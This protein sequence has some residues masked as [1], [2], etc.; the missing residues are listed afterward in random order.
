F[1]NDTATTEIY[2]LSLHDALPIWRG[3]PRP[4]EVDGHPTG[5]ERVPWRAARCAHGDRGLARLGQGCRRRGVEREPGPLPRPRPLV[6]HAVG[7]TAGPADDR[8]RAVA[9]RDHLAGAARLEPR[10]HEEE[11][12]T[13]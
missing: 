12:G 9:E 7:E 8:R 2:T 5:D 10:R 4:V 3:V 1:F 6:D 13:G 11:V